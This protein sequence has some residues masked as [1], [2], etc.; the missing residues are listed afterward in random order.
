MGTSIAH[1]RC[2]EINIYSFKCCNFISMKVALCLIIIF[3]LGC[4]RHL[5]ETYAKVTIF[6]NAR[7]L[8][9]LNNLGLP[10]DHVTLYRDSA[11]TGYFSYYDLRKVRKSG[12]RY[13]VIERKAGK[14]SKRDS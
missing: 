8:A 12:Y 7:Q 13:T 1:S 4:T 2:V 10:L 5:T 11:V 9:E 6:G 14:K 3:L